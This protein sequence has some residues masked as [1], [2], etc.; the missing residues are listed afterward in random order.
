MG[1]MLA[2]AAVH[3]GMRTVWASV[4]ERYRAYDLVLP[5]SATFICQAE[6]CNAYCCRAYSVS[7]GDAEAER[8][9]R[10][11]GRQLIELLES[12]DGE[13]IRLPLAQP[14]LLKREENRCAQLRDTLACG[15]YEGRPNACRLYP[16]FILFIEGDTLR[17]LH[18]GRERMARALALALRG[19]DTAP[20]CTALLVRH[21][22]C[23]GFTGPPMSEE[24]WLDLF[25]ETYRLQ[26]EP[27]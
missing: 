27:L 2:P 4:A 8:M 25:A 6:L 26:Y 23:P 22:E 3:Q 12:E 16:H 15:E 9:Q 11:S 14:Y 13:P 24:A 17:P 5:G 20:D 21:T 10:S 1:A 18:G 19:E 7:L